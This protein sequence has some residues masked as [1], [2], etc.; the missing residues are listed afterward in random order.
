MSKLL[1]PIDVQI[2]MRAQ[3]LSFFLCVRSVSRAF[4]LRRVRDSNPRY[5]VMRIPHFECGSFD[6]SDNSPWPWF[7]SKKVPT[8]RDF[9]LGSAT[10]T[11]TGVYGVRGRCPRPL[12]DSTKAF[13]F[14][15]DCKGTTKIR[16]TQIFL[17]F[18]AKKSKIYCKM[19][20]FC[21]FFRKY[22]RISKKSSTFAL[23]FG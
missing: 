22:L 15:S 11:R 7:V 18:F 8:N 6:H 10:R 1:C 3:R 21:I 19:H 13:C 9:F 2:K 4:R 5:D 17:Y 23:A 12:D 14:K 20:F 16:Y